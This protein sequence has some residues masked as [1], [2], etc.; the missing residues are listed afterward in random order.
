MGTKTSVSVTHQYDFVY[1]HVTGA[2]SVVFDP[3]T[4]QYI[5]DKRKEV[6]TS[7][8]SM[9]QSLACHRITRI[10]L[11]PTLVWYPPLRQT[12]LDFGEFPV[13]SDCTATEGA[14][15]T[16]AGIS[17][18]QEV[19]VN[20]GEK[21]EK[22]GTFDVVAGTNAVTF[23]NTYSRRLTE[24][25]LNT[26]GHLP[27]AVAEQ[28][29]RAGKKVPYYPHKFDLDCHDPETGE[30]AQGELLGEFPGFIQGAGTATY[31]GCP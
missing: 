6:K 15:T 22:S 16:A 29:A 11:L 31:Q 19:S 24:V 20:G 26:E 10:R 18:K 17:V 4:Q 14:T 5:S 21:S 3:A 25:K 23:T 13:G 7:A 9:F 12:G 8:N 1:T 28:Y 30:G 27:A 2:K